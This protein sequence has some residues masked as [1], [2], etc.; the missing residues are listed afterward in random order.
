MTI[1][2][3]CF[4]LGEPDNRRQGERRRQTARCSSTTRRRGGPTGPGQL[5]LGI[6][7]SGNARM[8]S[9]SRQLVRAPKFQHRSESTWSRRL[10]QVNAIM[11]PS[12]SH[13]GVYLASRRPKVSGSSLSATMTGSRR[14]TM[15]GTVSLRPALQRIAPGSRLGNGESIQTGTLRTGNS[16]RIGRSGLG[17]E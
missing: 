11:L 7:A 6:C 3:T 5:Q 17:M 16:F 4:H 12:P 13:G 1:E 10:P 9:Y 8:K 2:S 14:R 15:D